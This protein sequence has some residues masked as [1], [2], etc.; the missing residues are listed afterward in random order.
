MKIK[1][2]IASLC[3]TL[4]LSSFM[5]ACTNPIAQKTLEVTS[6]KAIADPSEYERVMADPFADESQKS[7][8]GL[9]QELYIALHKAIQEMKPTV[10]IASFNLTKQQKE[11]VIRTLSKENW[12][13][14]YYLTEAKLSDDGSTVSFSYLVNLEQG[15][16]E[17]KKLSSRLQHL[18]YNVA[19]EDYS[20]LTKLVAVFNYICENANY[21]S[22]SDLQAV[23]FTPFSV[24]MDGQGI[25]QGYADLMDYVLSKRGL[26]IDTLEG[27]QHAWNLVKLDG[28]YYQSD[29]TF[30]AGNGYHTANNISYLLMDDVKRNMKKIDYK[31]MQSNGNTTEAPKCTDNR[32][33]TYYDVGSSYA[34]D[35]KNNKV[36]IGSNEGILR[37]NL[38]TTEQE[39]ILQGTTPKLMEFFDGVLYYID[40]ADKKLYRLSKD[41]KP[42]L[43]DGE[44]GFES[45]VLKGTK[46]ICGKDLNGKNP[47]EIE[48]LPTPKGLKNASAQQAGTLKKADS[49]GFEVSVSTALKAEQDY[50][51]NVYMVDEKENAIPIHISVNEKENKLIVRPQVLVED[52]ESV[53]IYI[54]DDSGK[55]VFG[56]QWT[57][58]W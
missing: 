51:K 11:D 22:I 5:L 42:E 28:K 1:K 58:E 10:N 48:L 32:F 40:S 37:M 7:H 4:L 35:L 29:V 25:C 16:K 14:F 56:T 27:G 8:S 53:A 43:M 15:S 21:T 47:K 9:N 50:S 31:I 3:I 26:D 30:A 12:L 18:L 52:C 2:I 44:G 36:Y 19:L 45:L 46:L 23:A 41:K 55:S 20:E 39:N 6:I 54:M 49:H 34:F 33:S 57:L 17:Q 38:D 24:L 13:F